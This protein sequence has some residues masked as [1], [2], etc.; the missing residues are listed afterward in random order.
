MRLVI[1]TMIFAVTL[2]LLTWTASSWADAIAVAALLVMFLLALFCFARVSLVSTNE[3]VNYFGAALTLFFTRMLWMFKIIYCIPPSIENIRPMLPVHLVNVDLSRSIMINDN[4]VVSI[5]NFMRELNDSLERDVGIFIP[6]LYRLF[7]VGPYRVRNYTNL[8]LPTRWKKSCCCIP[9]FLTTVFVVICLWVSLI[10][11]GRYG[12]TGPNTIMAF[13][14]A[15]CCVL[16]GAFI[17]YLL[18]LCV[19]VYCFVLPMKKRIKLISTQ[20]GIQ[21][22]TFM[23]VIKQELELCVDMLECLDG[24]AQRQTRVVINLDLSD[25]LE[26]QKVLNMIHTLSIL[27]TEPGNSFILIFSV[28][29]RLLIKAV[30]QTLATLSGPVVTPHDYIKKIIDL[31]FYACEKYRYKIDGIL[32]ETFQN[33]LEE[34]PFSDN[35]DTENELEW[36]RHGDLLSNMTQ[37]TIDSHNSQSFHNVGINFLSNGNAKKS[38]TFMNAANNSSDKNNNNS[39]NN[40]QKKVSE[41]I[42]KLDNEEEENVIE[43]ISQLIRDNEN[44]SLNDVKRVMNIVSLKGRILRNCDV[45][46]HWN[47]LAVWVSLCD[48]WPYKAS[49]IVLLSQDKNLNFPSKMSVRRLFGAFGYAIP[50]LT[51]NEY[52]NSDANG[53][54]FDTFLSSHRPVLTVGDARQFSSVLFYVDPTI[55]KLMIDY[56]S[57]LRSDFSSKDISYNQPTIPLQHGSQ[58]FSNNK[59]I[60]HYYLFTVNRR[61]PKVNP[62]L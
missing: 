60:S 6:R 51:E 17:I 44:G 14:I 24:F 2:G 35:G 57:T 47:R 29:P 23:S 42:L 50:T 59:V 4:P 28:D 22:E 21:E 15:C 26:Q 31:P 8:N 16:A 9:S 53:N 10:F 54:Y 1:A 45:E 20:A 49:W 46:F 32:P 40:S 37:D 7:Q 43:D 41:R 3:K 19:A 13:Q 56:L 38:T 39:N 34:Q 5:V 55:R 11:F 58:S 18:R 61:L 25:S 52:S 33:V 62:C 12:I 27:L 30:E 36:D 48:S